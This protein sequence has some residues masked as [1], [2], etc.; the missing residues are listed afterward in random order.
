M[1][2]DALPIDDALNTKFKLVREVIEPGI[3]VG[4][5]ACVVGTDVS[6]AAMHRTAGGITPVFA[7][8]A[9]VDPLFWEACPGKGVDYPELYRSHYGR[10]PDDWRG[11]IVCKLWTGHAGAPDIRRAG[12]SGG[13]MTAVLIHLLET[14][15]IDGA[16]LVRQGHPSPAEA[17]FF[18]ARSREEIMACAQSVYIPV[19]V[20]DGLRALLP[21]ERYAM[22][23]LPEQ[24]AA[25]RVLQTAEHERA[26]QIAYV[27]GPYTGTALGSG[28][29]RALLRINRVPDDD[30]VASLQWRAGEWPGYLEIRTVAGRVIR[31]KKVYYNYLIP[32]YITQASLQS[33]DFANEFADLSVGDAWSPQFE[34]LGQGFSVVAARTPEICSI[35]EEM[36]SVG[37]LVLEPA[38]ILDAAAMH[39]HM[40]DFKKRGGYLRNEARRRLGRGAPDYG[41]KPV[42]IGPSRMV[43]EIIISSLFAICRSPVARWCLEQIPESVLGPLFNRLRL[44]WKAASKPAK[45]KGLSTLSMERH[46]PRWKNS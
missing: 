45:R 7:E 33:M 21:G 22:T 34:K 10:L 30:P 42:P 31:T 6:Q 28:A 19:S 37:A 20:L 5:G 16:V 11:G 18:I 41:L 25:L 43:V 27:L 4:C 40:V 29:I 26:R 44:S 2:S 38:D 32:F 36:A 35:V 15:R 9:K 12:A 1:S 3:C 46:R 24:S 23:C 14:G 17:S 39:G 13:V 8:Q